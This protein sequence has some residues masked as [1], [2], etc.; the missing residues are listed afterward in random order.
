MVENKEEDKQ[1]RISAGTHKLLAKLADQQGL[2]LKETVHL[3]LTYF[4][5]TKANPSDPQADLPGL[6][7]KKLAEKVDALDKRFIGFV[8]EQE[9]ELLKP[10]L[11]EV[12]A[13]RAQLGTTNQS[14]DLAEQLQESMLTTFGQ[15]MN[16][17]FLSPEYIDWY[18]RRT[19]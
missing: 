13:T 14:A 7:I 17:E 12:K 2:S 16:A 9:K 4:Q 8:R 19:T 10:I 1:L 3:M 15:A 18:N 11:S 5:V 6:G